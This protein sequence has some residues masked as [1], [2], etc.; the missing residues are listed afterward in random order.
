MDR[1]QVVGGAVSAE[2]FDRRT[3]IGLVAQ[4]L[5]HPL[6]QPLRRTAAGGKRVHRGYG[7]RSILVG[8]ERG[9][10][11]IPLGRRKFPET[12]GGSP[13]QPRV[14]RLGRDRQE[15]RRLL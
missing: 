15:R 7:H 12:F 8:G 13:S 14:G 9:E 4:E 10:P 1:R 5:A 2:Q 3:V 6:E 11:R